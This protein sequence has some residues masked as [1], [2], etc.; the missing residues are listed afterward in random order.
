MRA[1]CGKSFAVFVLSC[2]TVAWQGCRGSNGT[3]PAL[4]ELI[5]AERAFS[6]LSEESGLRTAFLTYLAEDGVVF[7]PEPVNGHEWYSGRPETPAVLTWDPVIADVSSAGDLGYTTGP[8]QMGDT[9]KEAT[10]FGEYVSVW[11][12]EPG[13]V[14]R[15]AVDAG[16]VHAKTGNAPVSVQ[17]ART[18]RVGLGR[19]PKT[20]DGRS[21]RDV[22]TDAARE[23]SRMCRDEGVVAGYTAF[24][25]DEICLLR[26]EELPV[27]GKDAV[28]E[29][30][31]VVE[32]VP[33]S[34]QMGEGASSS[35][36]L[37]YTYGTRQ[38]TGGD[39]AP[40]GRESYLLVWARGPAG[41]W[42]IVVDLAV[43]I[44]PPAAKDTD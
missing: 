29:T 35:D 40:G 42:K 30:V 8:W 9:G 18:D 43:A 10:I 16:T 13:Q 36:D 15:V 20:S 2:A 23:F 12:K 44:E 33:G 32:G 38:W 41:A 34:Q 6:H 4:E 11:R 24:A 31:R 14:W 26:M 28:L 25:A 27:T 5:G 7:R 37:G 1:R 39:G 19:T 22:V 21:G 17:R 3:P